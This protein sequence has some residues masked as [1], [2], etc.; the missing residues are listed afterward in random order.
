M[1][2]RKSNEQALLHEM[3]GMSGSCPSLNPNLSHSS[4]IA[5]SSYSSCQSSR[6]LL[7]MTRGCAPADQWFWSLPLV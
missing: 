5:S 2:S 7:H 6:S 1:D 3:S 4:S